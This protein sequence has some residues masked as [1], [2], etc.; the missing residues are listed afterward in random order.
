[1]HKFWEGHSTLKIVII[2]VF[3]IIAQS[4]MSPAYNIPLYICGFFIWNVTKSSGVHRT[5]LL[6]LLAYTFILDLI[7]MV[8]LGF[9]IHKTFSQKEHLEFSLEELD[10]SFSGYFM[11]IFGIVNFAVKIILV[12]MM[13]NSNKEI[14]SKEI[15]DYSARL[16]SSHSSRQTRTNER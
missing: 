2:T 5:R 4:M 16:T 6:Y 11:L 1:M 9:S 3:L 8:Y 14:S 12:I 15:P 7:W 10:I 13:I